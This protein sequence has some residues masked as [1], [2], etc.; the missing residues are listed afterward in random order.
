[1]KNVT[2]AGVLLEHS[3]LFLIGHPTA[4]HGTTG[5]WGILKGKV[6]DGETLCQAAFREF[7]EESSI[8]LEKQPG[9]LYIP[10]PFFQY[11]V[12]SNKKTVYVYWVIDTLGHCRNMTL[13]CP[14]LIPNTNIPEIDA[15][16][17][18]TAAE[19]IDLVTESQK[20]LFR[21]VQQ[22]TN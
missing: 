16:K 2:S 3:G 7:K 19:A 4:G 11:K 17:W 6:D 14:S 22:L 20:E 1:M 5:G 10:R 12:K 13:S 15:Y 9:I 8:D 18:V 21:T